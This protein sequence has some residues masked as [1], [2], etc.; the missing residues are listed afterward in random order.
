MK[1]HYP[2]IL[3][4]SNRDPLS[5]AR[6]LHF[7]LGRKTFLLGRRGA[8]VLSLERLDCGFDLSPAS[9]LFLT[10]ELSLQPVDG[11]LAGD[12]RSGGVTRVIRNSAFWSRVSNVTF[13]IDGI[14]V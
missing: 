14:G 12:E 8:R 9:H 7:A 1:K 4:V 2:A 6:A 10:G 5:W 3:S 11:R 13:L